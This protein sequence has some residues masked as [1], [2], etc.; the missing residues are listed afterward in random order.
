MRILTNSLVALALVSAVACGN[1]ESG[2]PKTRYGLK[3]ACI[4]YTITGDMFSGSE[5]LCFDRYGRREAKYSEQTIKVMGMTQK[6]HTA[7]F[8][9]FDK[10]GILYTYDYT[11]K[12]GTKMENPVKQVFEENDAKEVG[13]EM[14]KKMGGKKIGTGTVLGKKCDIWEI[15]DM[16]TKTWLWNWINLKTE[17]N[18]MGMKMTIE[19]TRISESFDKKK[20]EKP[21]V[22]YRDAGEALK[23]LD[24][25]KKFQKH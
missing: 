3:Q 22:E 23:G 6:N 5:T 15:K 16:G 19:A 1:A 24:A 12:S 9:D 2:N 11:T 18:M 17:T 21:N 8:V 7:T 10:D 20:L 14:M 4:E 25:L 13:L